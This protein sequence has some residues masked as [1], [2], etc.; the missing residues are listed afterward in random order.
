MSKESFLVLLGIGILLMPFLGLPSLWKNIF[1]ITAGL[2]IVIIAG[3]MRLSLRHDR[4][5]LATDKD[6]E[7]N[8]N[9]GQTFVENAE[10][11]G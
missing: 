5:A 7:T 10:S 8:S 9:S 3:L 1:F 11:V 2:L 6:Y 4:G